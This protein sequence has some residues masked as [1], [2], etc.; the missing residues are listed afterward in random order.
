MNIFKEILIVIA[1]IASLYILYGQILVEARNFHLAW[2]IQRSIGVI[3]GILL[4]L[5][6]ITFILLRIKYL[7]PLKF[8]TIDLLILFLFGGIGFFGGIVG[9]LK[10]NP[11]H[12]VVGDVLIFVS[13]FL[14]YL[15]A[16]MILMREK[17]EKKFLKLI[18]FITY[19]ILGLM[20]IIT[21]YRLFNYYST[22]FVTVSGSFIYLIPFLYFLVKLNCSLSKKTLF[23][24]LISLIIIIFS[25]KRGNLIGAIIAVPLVP[26]V[27]GRL[28]S[29][30]IKTVGIVALVTIILFGILAKFDSFSVISHYSFT[31]LLIRPGMEQRLLEARG[32]IRALNHDPFEYF[33]GKGMGGI[34]YAPETGLIYEAL[35]P[36]YHHNIHITPI[37]IFFRTGILGLLAFIIFLFF[38]P[39]FLYKK[40]R[41]AATKEGKFI[42]AFTL[43]YFIL[44]FIDSFKAYGIVNDVLLALFLGVARNQNL[45]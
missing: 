20:V 31:D 16:S 17:E 23:G 37:S 5:G 38:T 42:L 15:L 7:P 30:Y 12:F 10:N 25:L 39:T 1:I 3:I 18:T 26:V 40:Y 19:S 32:A 11:L 21:L 27:M 44:A 41:L 33:W 22:G 45:K 28:T 9:L 34:F 13:F 2:I 6:I 8:K 4:F 36:G 43:V 24:L 35:E 29:N 14:I